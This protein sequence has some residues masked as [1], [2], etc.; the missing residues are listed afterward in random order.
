MVQAGGGPFH[1]SAPRSMAR[2]LANIDSLTT[3]FDSSSRPIYAIDAERRIVYCN[4]ALATWLGMEPRRII[5]RLVEYHSQPATGD[6]ES[7]DDMPLADL[8]PPPR[9]IAGVACVGAL[10]CLRRDGRLVH[11]QAEYVPLGDI[12][13]EKANRVKDHQVPLRCAVLVVIS[14]DDMSTQEVASG[15]TAEP[16]FDE[17]HRTIRRFRR[18]QASHYSIAS[19]LGE[20]AAMQKVRAQVAAAAASGANTLVCGARGS[21]RGHVARAIYFGGTNADS[22][23][24]LPIDCELLTD[25]LLRRAIDGFRVLPGDA[26]QRPMLLLENLDRMS[27]PHQSLLLAAIHQERL[28]ARMIATCRR[29][30]AE[31]AG[32][33]IREMLDDRQPG[34]EGVAD[35]ATID[36]ALLNIISTITIDLP[37]LIERV[38]DLAILA[39]YFLEACNQGSGKQVGSLAPMRSICW[40]FTIGPG[41]WTSCARR[42]PLPIGLVLRTRLRRPI[43]P[44]SFAMR[45]AR[46]LAGAGSRSRSYSTSCWRRL[47]R[48]RLSA[49]WLSRAVIK[50]KRQRCSA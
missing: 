15:Q 26:M 34:G 36:S 50:V 1:Q 40:R 24:L 31:I 11:R 22:T 2:K 47:K 7:P 27:A 19:L 33:E 8:C 6:G 10:S 32:K 39:Q 28:S 23:K 18:G 45:L 12:G 25:D 43:C 49:H 42:L 35:P 20:S 29:T 30:T 5:G 16:V 37:P 46:Q 14:M 21:G 41:N 9:A 38:E 13:R 3:L 44:A 4:R 48:K 17:T